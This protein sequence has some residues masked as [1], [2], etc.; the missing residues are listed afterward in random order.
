MHEEALLADLRRKLEEIGAA[1]GRRITR[2]NV[3]IGALAHVTEP[4][5]RARWTELAAGTSAEGAR[6]E[7]ESSTRI[8]DPRATGVVLVSVDLDATTGGPSRALP[9]AL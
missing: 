2:V 9:R 5:L 8:A 3:W 4:G 1:H 7:V 6:L